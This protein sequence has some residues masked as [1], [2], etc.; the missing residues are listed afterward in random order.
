MRLFHLLHL[1]LDAQKTSFGSQTQWAIQICTNTTHRMVSLRYLN[2]NLDRLW[3]PTRTLKGD[4]ACTFPHM[5][6]CLCVTQFTMALIPE[7]SAVKLISQCERESNNSTLREHQNA[8]IKLLCCYVR[9]CLL[10]IT[11][12]SR[13]YAYQSKTLQLAL[14]REIRLKI[15]LNSTQLW[16]K[17]GAVFVTG[18]NFLYS[19]SDISKCLLCKRRVEMVKKKPTSKHEKQ[20][21]LQFSLSSK[22]V[23]EFRM[24]KRAFKLV[25]LYW[26]S[27]KMFKNAQID[28]R[29]SH[30]QSTSLQL[31]GFIN[32]CIMLFS[33]LSCLC[34]HSYMRLLISARYM[35]IFMLLK[36]RLAT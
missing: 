14:V 15:N 25:V 24:Q 8:D 26:K 17:I 12:H 34:T 7:M 11:T 19:Y 2:I 28:S 9:T 5:M 22:T 32:T 21:K 1:G 13:Q 18:S 10:V 29:V 35:G 31:L 3:S 33:I 20:E 6:G 23:R 27:F 36:I 4:T 16:L 30:L